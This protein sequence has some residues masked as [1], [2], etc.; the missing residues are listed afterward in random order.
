MAR[1]NLFVKNFGTDTTE[2]QIRD[3]FSKYGEI[4]NVKIMMTDKNDG[5]G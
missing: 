3:Y 1:L 2:E 5:S 4:K